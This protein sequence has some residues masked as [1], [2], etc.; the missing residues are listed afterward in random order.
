M[1]LWQ[2]VLGELSDALSFSHVIERRA[3]VAFFALDI[4]EQ[5]G[6]V[7]VYK[8]HYRLRLVARI[9][10]VFVIEEVGY[11]QKSWVHPVRNVKE[12]FGY[13]FGF[14]QSLKH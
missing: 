12:G 6:E 8:F 14:I 9:N 13:R 4:N 3:V 2:P 5:E 10:L 11:F 1:A 7:L